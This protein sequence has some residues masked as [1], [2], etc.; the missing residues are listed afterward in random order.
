MAQ[1]LPLPGSPAGTLAAK[2]GSD[3]CVAVFL[4]AGDDAELRVERQVSP[5]VWL[6]VGAVEPG[7]HV[8][9]Y[10]DTLCEP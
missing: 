7:R 5:S 3:D 1:Q 8:D 10:F 4:V 6:A 9:E 2:K